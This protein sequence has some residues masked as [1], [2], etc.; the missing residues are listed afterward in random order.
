M[1]FERINCFFR[2]RKTLTTQFIFDVREWKEVIGCQISA[3]WRM[4]HQFDLLAC[5]ISGCLSRCVKA[6]IVVVE[7]D[8]S[9]AAFFPY[10]S[11]DFWQ[12][13]GCVPFRIDRP[14]LF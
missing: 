5:E 14:T 10:S 6:R 13:N 3:V 11:E 9:L 1:H 2:R 4:T 8:P 12:A 7:N